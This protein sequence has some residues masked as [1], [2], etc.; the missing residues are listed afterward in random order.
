VVYQWIGG[1]P[2]NM[3]NCRPD[4]DQISLQVDAYAPTQSSSTEIAK[5]IRYAVELQSYI[6]FY[7]GN[8]RDTETGLYRTTFHLDWIVNR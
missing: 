3:L 5:A 6:T 1:D 2:Y 8:M 7:A 4:A